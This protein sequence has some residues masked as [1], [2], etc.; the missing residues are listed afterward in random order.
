MEKQIEMFTMTAKIPG[1][2]GKVIPEIEFSVPKH[3]IYGIA[4][5]ASGRAIKRELK[6]YVP[7]PAS[8]TDTPALDTVT[9]TQDTLIQLV[10]RNVILDIMEEM[11][12][13][14]KSGE[15]ITL[16]DM[17]EYLESLMV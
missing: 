7:A 11:P 5:K 1:F 13:L 16:D 2:L 15:I 6:K 3:V 4:V 9:M 8:V 14:L 10:R 17:H 12:A